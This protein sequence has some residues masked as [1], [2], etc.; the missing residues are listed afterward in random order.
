MNTE[1][2]GRFGHHPHAATDF[3]IEVE[4][5]QGA[6][7]N[8]THD[9]PNPK[10]GAEEFRQRLERAMDFRV[11]GDEIAVNAKALLRELEA[12]ARGEAA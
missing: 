2:L 7:F 4:A 3:C 10:I 11:G 1:T 9:I 8:L 6:H 12:S 5:L